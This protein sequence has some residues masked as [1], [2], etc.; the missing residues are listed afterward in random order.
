MIGC[1]SILWL[2]FGY[3]CV[4][5][6]SLSISYFES[7][8]YPLKII[9]YFLIHFF[10]DDIKRGRYIYIYILYEI[11]MAKEKDMW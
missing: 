2:E 11:Y 4:A 3:R 10:L 1:N 8:P 5:Q 9:A 6:S 7:L